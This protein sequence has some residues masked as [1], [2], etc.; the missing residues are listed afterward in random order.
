MAQKTTQVYTCSTCGKV[1]TKKGHLCA[2]SDSQFVCEFCGAEAVDPRHL[3][4]PKV[5]QLRYV[6]EACGRVAVSRSQLCAP[7][8]IPA[9]A[10]AKPAKTAKAAAT[11][12][13]GGNKSGNRKKKK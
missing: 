1:S 7:R 9:T 13:R 8:Q 5:G 3:C 10:S 11:K 6:C 12:G 4:F 2:P